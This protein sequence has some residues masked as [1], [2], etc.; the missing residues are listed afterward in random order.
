MDEFERRL[1]S[2]QLFAFAAKAHV[3]SG[4]LHLAD[5]GEL[6]VV[7]SGLADDLGVLAAEMTSDLDPPRQ[8]GDG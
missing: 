7:A 1:V 3:L 2:A 4:R 8:V 5:R 6:A